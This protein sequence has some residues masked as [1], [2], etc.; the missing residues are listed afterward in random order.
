MR[1]RP[2]HLCAEWGDELRPDRLLHHSCQW[3]RHAAPDDPGLHQRHSNLGD[4]CRPASTADQPGAHAATGVTA[5][6]ADGHSADISSSSGRT[7]CSISNPAIATISPEG[8]VTAM[9]SGTVMV[10]AINEGAQGILM[11]RVA[12]AAADSDGDGITDEE[13]IRLGM[14]PNNPADALLDEDHDGL[15][16][17]EEYRR[18]TDP[19]NPDTDGDGIPDGDEVHGT[20]GFVTNPLLADTDGDGIRDKTEIQTG[21]NPTNA[22][23]FNLAQALTGIR[24]NPLISP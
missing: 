2:C 23:S 4:A 16:A 8:L 24:V 22:S 3:F 18:G 20:L 15:T 5:S 14:N 11:L 19:H 13:E 10:Q 12:F 1:T 17:L 7:S 9:R 21:S 6:Y